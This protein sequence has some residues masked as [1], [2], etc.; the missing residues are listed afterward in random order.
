MPTT[1]KKVS[2]FR[3]LK[4]IL[5]FVDN[6][7]PVLNGY[8]EEFGD[9]SYRI[10]LGGMNKIIVTKDTKLIQHVLQKNHKNYKKSFI[11][12]D[13]LAEYLG[14]GILTT[15][16]KYWL[17]Q[18]RLIQP[19]FHKKALDSFVRIMKTEI[20]GHVD[21]MK[22]GIQHGNQEFMM[23]K[24][25]S[26]LTLKVVSKTLFSTG[27]KEDEI[28]ILG[29]SIDHLQ[30]VLVQKIR[31]PMFEWWREL[32]GDNKKNKAIAQELY[33]LIMNII[34][35]RKS[36]G[37]NYGD[38]LDMLIAARYEGTDE[39]MSDKQLM[40]E[41]I[42]LFVAGYETTA[43]ALAW[44]FYLLDQNRDQLKKVREE[45]ASIPLDPDK[46]MESLM[47]L[48]FTRQVISESMRIYPP[49]WI[50]DRESI[51]KDECSDLEIN[52][53]QIINLYIYGVHHDPKHWH[54][55]EQFIPSRFEK[56]KI[57]QME[58]YTYFPFG[59]G[60]RLC[61][62]NQF[63]MM[64]M[65]LSLYLILQN[66]DFKVK[67]GHPIELNPNVTLRSKHGIKMISSLR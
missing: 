43:N 25:M 14:H 37:E 31:K 49:A 15:N 32:K 36:S 41:C 52:G 18:R 26:R 42:V 56:D 30:A 9:E 27:I 44:T 58:P 63:A 45:I 16:G 7:I 61:I 17:K 1:L 20:E 33:D 48:D 62:G 4:N 54:N 29:D 57:K 67:E 39:G 47:K 5:K 59:G 19:G 24:E 6:P 21:E 10:N 40:D 34:K 2:Q 13:L 55:P 3:V 51:A 35:E 22:E 60:P 66:F 50:T 28:N 11:Q 12:T 23:L 53:K 46:P 8:F 65:Q 64:E 38:I